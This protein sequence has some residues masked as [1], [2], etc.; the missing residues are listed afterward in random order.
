[1]AADDKKKTKID[2]KARL[3]K[4][5]AGTGGGATVPLPV[6]GSQTG[7]ASGPPD[8]SPVAGGAAPASKPSG[9][10]SAPMAPVVP[11]GIAPPPGISPGI[12]LPPFAQQQRPAPAPPPPKPSAAQQTIK[13]D[14]GE[15]VERERKRSAKK[16]AIYSSLAVVLGI[17][18]GFGIGGAKERGDRGKAAVE[19]AGALEKDIKVANEKMK[20]LSQKLDSAAEKLGTKAYPA[21]FVNELSAINIPFDAFN[22]ENKQ[23]GSL[24]GKVLRQVLTYTTAVQDLNKTKDSLKNL[25]VAA[26][27]PVEKS[28]KEE[29]EPVVSFSVVFKKDGEKMLA[30]LV[31]NKEPF[32][33]GG[34]AWPEKYKINRPERTPQGVKAVEKDAVRWVKGELTGNDPLVLPVDPQSVAAFTSEQLVFK[35][36]GALRDLR[37]L[38][39][40]NKENPTTETAGLLKEGDD[41]ANELHKISLKR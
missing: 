11:A 7:V 41:L 17:G 13:V 18:I 8:S 34:T 14:V 23:V 21:E 15:E 36:A 24:P 27:V 35:L 20:E 31:P 22:L 38:L 5:T 19:G 30:E 33:F 16:V 1:M 39:E 10:P 9:R 25:L 26:Q 28:W 6:P 32:P 12:P 37:Q 29:K 40:G 2:L 3:G 4:T